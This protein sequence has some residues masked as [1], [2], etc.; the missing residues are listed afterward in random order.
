MFRKTL[1]ATLALAATS[2]V[3]TH[4]AVIINEIDYD[5]PGTD[6]TEFV[7]LFNP[8]G[9]AQDLSGFTL[10]GFNGGATNDTA[11]L[12]IPLSGSIPA[13]GF[14]TIGNIAGANIDPAA[15]TDLIQNGSGDALGVYSSGTF[16]AGT[17]T[18]TTEGLEDGV[19]YE[20]QNSFPAEFELSEASD[21][22]TPG[23][24][25]R[26]PD[27]TGA[28]AFSTQTTL[29]ASNVIVPVPEPTTLA[30]LGL[31]GAAG[32]LRRRK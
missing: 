10:V 29:G 11:Y 27:G 19:V 3:A 30:A 16:T 12:V 24:I 7:E 9:T 14:F 5:Q 18:P 26:D 31:V 1:L 6:A 8:D 13:G 17:S 21:G 23:S 4:A 25:Q 28:F 2:A 22:S 20:G 15:D 32:L